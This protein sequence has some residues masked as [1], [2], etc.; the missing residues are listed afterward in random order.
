MKKKKKLKVVEWNEKE[1]MSK[2]FAI[3][4]VQ[5]MMQFCRLIYCQPK[6]KPFNGKEDF[7]VTLKQLNGL[8]EFIENNVKE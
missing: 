4:T 5:H 3:A 8:K 6:I 1:L 2:E 7:E